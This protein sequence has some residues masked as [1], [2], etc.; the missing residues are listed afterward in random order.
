MSSLSDVKYVVM[1]LVRTN[2]GGEMNLTE[3]EGHYKRQE[4]HELKSMAIKFDFDTVLDMI[5]SWPEFTVYGYSINTTIRVNKID[6]I[7]EMNQRH[8]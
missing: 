8:K 6:H 5:E 3:L 2:R 1:G 4:G 7:V